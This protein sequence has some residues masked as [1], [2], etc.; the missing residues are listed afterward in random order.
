MIAA[1]RD[2]L[3]LARNE[4][5]RGV[6]ARGIRLLGA[7]F[8]RESRARIA[9]YAREQARLR[10]VY[11]I[12]AETPIRTYDDQTRAAVEAWAEG[13][14]GAQFATTS[15]STAQPKKIAFTRARLAA[16]KRENFSVVARIA[17]R[18]R[19][20]RAGLFVLS[21]LAADDSLSSLLLEGARAPGFLMGLLMPTRHVIRPEVAALVARY[22]P[23]A[24]RLWLLVLSDPG[25]LYCTNPSTL[26]LFLASLDDDWPAATALIRDHIAG[27]LEAG[28]LRVARAIA[29][30]GWERRARRIASSPV[31]LP[32]AELAPG[33]AVYVCWDG[34]YVRPYLDQVR[35]YLPPERFRQ[36]PMY[37]MSTE[38]LETVLHFDG[39]EPRYLAMAPG[40][41]YEF[42]PED[43]PDETARLLP[44]GALEPGRVY[45]M[46]VS[47]GYGLRRYQTEDLFECR[48]RVGGVPDLRFLRRRGLT[49]S[50]TGEKL[51][52]AQ[53]VEAYARVRE[54]FPALAR[55]GV[56][57]A[58]IPSLPPGERL[59]SYRLLLAHPGARP[60]ELDGAAVARRVD[61]HLATINR[62]LAE[63]RA[64]GRLGPTLAVVMR[65]DAAA[66]A[67]E[68]RARGVDASAR[69]WDSQFKLLPLYR[70]LWHE[71]GL[72]G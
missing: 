35:A 17:R 6:V 8:E 10:L 67:L 25:L 11:G 33:L 32:A 53:L 72:P 42:L 47:D 18:H 64:S 51:T 60:E 49:Y 38:T 48:G 12:E 37:S 9:G 55:A 66:A 4:L 22:G 40:V 65:Y 50:F 56:Q 59:P 57:L 27:R 63:K 21:G 58:M 30:S 7:A 34:G 3:A 23:T 5:V 26:A 19:L 24:V 13:H 45:A 28:P 52:D 14:P 70:R 39:G 29:S 31:A 71:H 44:P 62:E 15:G 2:A 61:A 41:L 1:M 20:E 36:V 69:A 54:E 68:P 43:A 46:V 16:I